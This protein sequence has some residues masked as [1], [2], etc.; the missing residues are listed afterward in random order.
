MW[1]GLK[2]VY[3]MSKKEKKEFESTYEQLMHENSTF[4][5]EFDQRYQ[6]F[7][8]S[9]LILAIMQED[10]TSIRKLAKE[11][12]VSPSLIQDLKTGKKDNLTLRSFSNIIDALDYD[13][14]LKKRK[15]S[16]P[17]INIESPKPIN[18]IYI[19]K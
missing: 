1:R 18:Y 19:K 7:I 12:G 10:Q 2:R 17:V 4:K 8:L 14:I 5:K 11:A 9:E 16:K 15:K 3:I 6:Q 13:L